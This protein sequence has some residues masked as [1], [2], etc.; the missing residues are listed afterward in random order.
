MDGP[1]LRMPIAYF[2]NSGSTMFTSKKDGYFYGQL[3]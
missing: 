1:V 3:L 2:F